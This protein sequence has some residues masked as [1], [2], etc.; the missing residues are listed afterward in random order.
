MSDNIEIIMDIETLEVFE[1]IDLD[2]KEEVTV[3]DTKVI[4]E[5][6]NSRQYD[7]LGRIWLGNGYYY[8]PSSFIWGVEKDRVIHE[9]S[10]KNKHGTYPYYRRA[11]DGTW[12]YIRQMTQEEALWLTLEFHPEL[13]V[14]V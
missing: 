7:E 4:S 8:K 1:V 10:P 5:E 6:K 12:R 11:R 9:L 2:E 13:M 3:T 14:F